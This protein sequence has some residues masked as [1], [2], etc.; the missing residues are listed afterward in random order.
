MRKL[1]TGAALAA[2][3][4]L[5]I[6][7]ALAAEMPST[8]NEE[9]YVLYHKA[10]VA[11]ERCRDLDFDQAQHSAMAKVIN[12]KIAHDIGAKRLNLIATAKNEAGKMTSG[13]CANKPEVDQW[14][15]I[16]DSELKPAL[17]Y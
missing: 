11:A 15:A 6:G 17:P 4:T 13:G 12:S 8:P 14:L 3:V 1:F 16:Y 5:G 2:V 9:T 10:I 7:N